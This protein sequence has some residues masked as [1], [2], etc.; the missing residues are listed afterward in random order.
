MTDLKEKIKG[1]GGTYT[2][3]MTSIIGHVTLIHSNFL[4]FNQLFCI[5]LKNHDH[6]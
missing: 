1:K 4:H 3:N 2:E 5:F 6:P